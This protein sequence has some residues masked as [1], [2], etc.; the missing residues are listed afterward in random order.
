MDVVLFLRAHWAL[1]DGVAPDLAR[2]HAD[3]PYFDF[4]QTA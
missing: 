3:F 1:G 2:I 4:G